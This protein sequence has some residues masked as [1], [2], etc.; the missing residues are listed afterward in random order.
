MT[1]KLESGK[2]D[3]LLLYFLILP[4]ISNTQTCNEHQQRIQKLRSDNQIGFP[5][6][7]TVCLIPLVLVTGQ[8]SFFTTLRVPIAQIF[9]SYWEQIQICILAPELVCGREKM[10]WGFQPWVDAV[11]HILHIDDAFMKARKFHVEQIRIIVPPKGTNLADS[12][13]MAVFYLPLFLFLWA[14]QN[15][16]NKDDYAASWICWLL[17]ASWQNLGNCLKSTKNRTGSEHTDCRWLPQ[18][19]FI[20]G[21]RT[22]KLETQILMELP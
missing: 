22:H 6:R 1:F 17:V 5:K 8:G 9:L 20:F 14:K 15:R 21:S 7:Q 19:H 2:H 12:A 18:S 11:F 4:I 3:W 16:Q 10:K 13:L